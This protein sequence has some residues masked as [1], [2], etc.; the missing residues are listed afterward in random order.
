MI[1]GLGLR[2]ML[3]LTRAPRAGAAGAVAPPVPLAVARGPLV[4]LHAPGPRGVR[5]AAGLACRLHALRPGLALL[6][7]HAPDLELRADA[8]PPG[9]IVHPLAAVAPAVLRR[10]L[11]DWRPGAVVQVGGTPWPALWH[12]ASQAGAG[13][14]WANARAGRLPG[15][16]WFWPGLQRHLLRGV[17]AILAVDAAAKRLLCRDGA[18][19]QVC[20]VTGPLA[21][22]RAALPH[23]E[24]EREALAAHLGARPVWLAA[25][26][27]MDEVAAV[28]AAHRAAR[29]AAH[30]LLLIV[31]PAD[32]AE[33]PA[34][35]GL[36]ADD[37]LRVS[38]RGADQDPAEEDHVYVADTDGEL[39]LW[40]RLA[41]IT[42]PGGSLGAPG[43][44]LRDPLE[45][46]AL[47]SAVVHGPRRGIWGDAYE[48]LAAA[49]ASVLVRGAEGLGEA[50]SDLQAPDRC[51][52]LAHDAWAVATEGADAT[53]AAAEAVL[54]LVDAAVPSGGG[55]T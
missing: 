1:G 48:A 12:C 44:G 2:L 45:P 29:R 37:G 35:A 15:L 27:P 3:A 36:V 18:A 9:A 24:A 7:T 4:W 13:L 51:A 33:G 30:R 43:G 47:G 16:W 20:R 40:Y 46:A 41:A 26:L 19:A 55:G 32:P 22:G 53:E 10:M 6:V 52:M 38:R 21:E 50:I 31:V 14:I 39:G 49:R 34:I 42:Y 17:R 54:A 11:A 23:T 8:V 25:G 5:A 28:L